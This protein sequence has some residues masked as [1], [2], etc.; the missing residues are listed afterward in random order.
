MHDLYIVHYCHPGCTPFSSITR[1]PEAEA[2]AAAEL[3]ARQ[4]E[5]RA[6][7]RFAD[8]SNYYPLRIRTE[9]WL[10]DHFLALG[11]EPETN[12]PLYFTLADSDFLRDWFGGGERITALP[13][14][15]IDARH[16][17][18][19][20]GDSC[21]RMDSPERRDPITKQT[22]LAEAAAHS[23]GPEAFLAE[24]QQRYRYI[25]AQLWNDSYTAGKY[26]DAVE[27][28]QTNF[29]RTKP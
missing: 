19:T 6:F 24:V 22:L 11:G 7:S 25:E 27:L 15:S 5:G 8:F 28:H 20:Y 2:Y 26:N 17:S 16:I 14:T 4:N 18:F 13:L 3:L 23:G 1:L 21:A 29:E 12:H 10:Y 9:E